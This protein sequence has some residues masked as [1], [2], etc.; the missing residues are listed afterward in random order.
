MKAAYIEAAG[1][2]EAFKYGDLPDPVAGAGEVLIR[3]AATTVNHLDTVVRSGIRPYL[4]ITPPHILGSEASGEIVAVGPGVKGLAVGDRV[5]ARTKTG[6][7]AELAIAEAGNVTKL[8]DNISLEDAAGF[9][10]TGATAYR[11]VGRRANLQPGESV[12]ITAGASGTASMMVQIAKAAGYYVIAT[13]GGTRKRDLV[14]GLGADATIDHYEDDIAARVLELTGGRGVDTAIDAVASQPLFEAVMNSLRPAG[15][16]VIYGNMVT[17][18][19]TF[20]VRTLFSKGIEIVGG[21][22]GDAGQLAVD[23]TADNIA[24]MRLAARGQI[25]M[26]R[27]RVLPISEAA[28]AHAAME[29]HETAGKIVLTA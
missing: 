13:A 4:K 7:Y 24:F 5:S 14:M 23:R 18:Q 10:A 6:S 25:K 29:A 16:L 17:T 1:G 26:L 19:L 3:V 11:L 15:R 28:A 2:P 8:P 21:Q 12:L 20:N 9:A 27:D 22:G